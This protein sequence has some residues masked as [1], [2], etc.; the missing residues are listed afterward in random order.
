MQTQP[1]SE[2]LPPY[3]CEIF[4][5]KDDYILQIDHTYLV[6]KDSN[7][8]VVRRTDCDTSSGITSE[9]IGSN[10]NGL[11]VN[12]LG[13]K[14]EL[15]HI[16]WTPLTLTEDWDGK[17]IP[18]E[19]LTYRYSEGYY[20]IFI[21]IN[22]IDGKI[23]THPRYYDKEEDFKAEVAAFRDKFAVF[24][25]GKP[26]EMEFEISVVHKPTFANYWHCQIE[27]AKNTDPKSPPMIDDPRGWEKKMLRTFRNFLV[28]YCTNSITGEIPKIDESRYK[29]KTST[30]TQL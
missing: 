14:F 7:L 21:N 8:Y 16:R 1:Q 22:E 15:I 10:L 2:P 30:S 25:K 11:S 9:M 3:P 23:F 6:E 28:P 20:S 19:N 24:A 13:G 26:V 18:K 17:E 4:P 12:L 5:V 27:V 29:G